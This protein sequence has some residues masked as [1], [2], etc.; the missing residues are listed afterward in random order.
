MSENNKIKDEYKM[1]LSDILEAFSQ[2]DIKILD[3]QKYS[4]DDFL[5]LNSTLKENYKTANIIKEITNEFFSKLGNYK[6]LNFISS[7]LSNIDYNVNKYIE[8]INASLNYLEK[9]ILDCNKTIVPLN[10]FSQNMSVLKLLFSNASLA[11]VFLDDENNGLENDSIKNTDISLKSIK[12]K[13][14]PVENN[15]SAIREKAKLLYDK[16]EMKK[17]DLYS[18]VILNVEKVKNNITIIEK[19]NKD[20]NENYDTLNE[21]SKKCS[22]N[23]ESI[24]TNLQYH[25]IIRQKME[26]VQEA[27]KL[28]VD[29]LNKVA[30]K[31]EDN[32]KS[33]NKILPYVVQIPQISEI[34]TAQMLHTNKDFQKA[35]DA[36]TEKMNEIGS[37]ISQMAR[38]FNSIAEFKYQ[39]K[40]I[41]INMTESD[42]KQISGKVNEVF[43]KYEEDNKLL[44]D[45]EKIINEN[46]NDFE[47]VESM[48]NALE[49]RAIEEINQKK[50]VDDRNKEK[51]LKSEEI[52][53]IFA[54][55]KDEKEKLRKVFD[56]SLSYLQE[57]KNKTEELSHKN[58]GSQVLIKSIED[59]VKK[60]NSI[61]DFF[62]FIIENKKVVQEKSKEVQQKNK[63][64]IKESIY[65]NYFG[66]ITDEI[67]NSF[68]EIKEIVKEGKLS[69]INIKDD[70][71]SFKQIED[72]YTMK[73]ERIIH[74]KA[75]SSLA[76]GSDSDIDEEDCSEE[77]NDV[78]LF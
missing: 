4:S 11:N 61:K 55:N 41:S 38:V 10:N 27:H 39:G 35:I 76:K 52:L 62:N 64:A 22:D 7:D 2:I 70:E 50:C 3:L 14:S 60:I 37:S 42:F 69:E 53:K 43:E 15:I 68:N 25:D 56:N 8:S 32:E 30:H 29:E 58:E 23:V 59:A 45:L 36:I 49:K 16:L 34:Q 75:L 71:H 57:V 44:C 1:S 33:T 66:K 31:G 40:T 63:N 19:Y 24:I 28:I 21:L 78:E 46:K 77:G 54:D 18:N 72:Y 9:I 13:C 48:D 65:Y 12:E 26:H 67:I 51:V 5:A 6:N 73:A 74:N 20:A 47:I 17:D